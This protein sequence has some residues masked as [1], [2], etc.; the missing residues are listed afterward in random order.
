MKEISTDLTALLSKQFR[1]KYGILQEC[2]EYDDENENM[3]KLS[4]AMQQDI[5]S[6]KTM[7]ERNN[8]TITAM[9]EHMEDQIFALTG[10][11]DDLA[12]IGDIIDG[13]DTH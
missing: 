6:Y 5:V 7:F 3:E 9:A 12:I 13:I 10:K 8:L 2:T 4:Q 11:I 1:N